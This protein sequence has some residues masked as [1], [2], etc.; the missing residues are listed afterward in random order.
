MKIEIIKIPIS[1]I[2]FGWRAGERKSVTNCAI[3]TLN[4]SWRCAMRNKLS[5]LHCSNNH[6]NIKMCFFKNCFFSCFQ[7][8]QFQNEAAWKVLLLFPI[9]NWWH[10]GGLFVYSCEHCGSYLECCCIGRDT[11]DEDAR[12]GNHET[13]PACIPL[14]LRN[15]RYAGAIGTLCDTKNN[16]SYFLMFVHFTVITIVVFAIYLCGIFVVSKW[17]TSKC[18]QFKLSSLKIQFLI[19][20]AFKNVENIMVLVASNDL[21]CIRGCSADIHFG[22]WRFQCDIGWKRAVHGNVEIQHTL[23]HTD[24]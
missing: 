13:G 16:L 21:A 4:C 24:G 20:F 15:R 18:F 7:S 8:F 9:T 6:I 10:R 17:K 22:L 2:M 14:D 19:H 5:I 23:A 11:D 3:S 12:R 1:L